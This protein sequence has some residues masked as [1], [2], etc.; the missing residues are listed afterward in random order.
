MPTPPAEPQRMPTPPA[1]PE[2]PS[3]PKNMP[4]AEPE[5]PP[6]EMVDPSVSVN[7]VEVTPLLILRCDKGIQTISPYLNVKCLDLGK[8]LM[9]QPQANKR[10]SIKQEPSEV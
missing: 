7:T 3:E 5:R 8:R 6:M 2:I 4:P 10:L 9:E 1:E